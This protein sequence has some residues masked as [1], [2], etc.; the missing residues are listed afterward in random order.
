MYVKS[1]LGSIPTTKNGNLTPELA[2]VIETITNACKEIDQA[3]QKGALA[4]LLGSAGNENVQGE[5]QK[6]SMCYQMIFCLMPFKHT[7]R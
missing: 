4:D 6:N 1:H 7:L 3:I 2:Q 5:T